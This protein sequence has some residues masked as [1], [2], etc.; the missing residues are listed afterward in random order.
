MLCGLWIKPPCTFLTTWELTSA[1]LV[2]LLPLN[3]FWDAPY[4]TAVH[5]GLGQVREPA[6]LVPGSDNHPAD[7]LIDD[8]LVDQ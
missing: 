4:Q 3:I 5:A 6:G 8:F 1:V 7:V 2:T